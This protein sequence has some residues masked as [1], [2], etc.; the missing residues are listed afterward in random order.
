MHGT[1]PVNAKCVSIDGDADRLVYFFTDETGETTLL[2]GDKIAAL[3]AA[4]VGGLIQRCGDALLC[5]CENKSSDGSSPNWSTKN[6]APLTV[7]VVQTAYANGASTKF[8]E[9]KLNLKTK[10]TPTG[11]KWLH[12][13]AEKFD[14]GVY[15]ESN[16]HGTALFSEEALGRIRSVAAGGDTTNGDVEVSSDSKSAAFAL[17]ALAR[18]INPAVGDALSGVLVVE[19]IL[20]AKGWG[21][22]EWNGM[23]HDLPSK[24]V[25]VKVLDRNVVVTEDA[26]RRATRPVGLQAA[27]DEKVRNAGPDARAFARPSGTEDVVRVYAE[28]ATRKGA[29][30]L[31]REVAKLVYQFAGGVGDAP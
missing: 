2:D 5:S 4:H 20:R 22:N 16:G 26:E 18:A 11:V 7:G 9:Q 15:F 1:F 17:L 23:Y 25:K 21:L 31:A 29:D 19:A 12:P 10:C 8:V 6:R 28:A 14:V 30:D 24:Q 3:L 13:A 27:I